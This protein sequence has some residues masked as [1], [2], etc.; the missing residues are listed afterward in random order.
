MT[1]SAVIGLVVLGFFLAAAGGAVT[2]TR[3]GAQYLGKELAAMMGA[4]FGAS[5]VPA[6]VV[7]LLVL[8]LLK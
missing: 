1:V 5:V 3:I 4:L 2:G 6:T 8:G 7:G